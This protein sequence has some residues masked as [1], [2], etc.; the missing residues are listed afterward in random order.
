MINLARRFNTRAALQ[1][2]F[3]EKTTAALV[4]TVSRIVGN[5]DNSHFVTGLLIW[6]TG[7][8]AAR[9]LC[10]DPALRRR[11]AW[12]GGA[13]DGEGS[14]PCSDVERLHADSIFLPEFTFRSCV[15]PHTLHIQVFTESM[16]K[17]VG[18]VRA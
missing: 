13:T 9:R 4:P 8:H 1:T 16:S 12:L 5:F 2:Y 18:P 14:F 3:V 11:D 7:L 6:R 17:P 10:A 15:T